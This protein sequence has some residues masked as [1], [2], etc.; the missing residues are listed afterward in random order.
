MIRE[1]CD[2]CGKEFKWPVMKGGRMV[3]KN[4]G[5]YSEEPFTLCTECYSSLRASVVPLYS[6]NPSMTDK[7]DEMFEAYEESIERVEVQEEFN[8]R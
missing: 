2:R 3:F 4:E 5:G 6:E 8:G 7:D 1:F